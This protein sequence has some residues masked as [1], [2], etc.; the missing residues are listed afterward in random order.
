[1]HSDE[2]PRDS[3]HQQPPEVEVHPRKVKRCLFE[4]E[5]KRRAGK[6]KTEKFA[7]GTYMV[8]GSKGLK[9]YCDTAQ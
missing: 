9:S 6:K 3:G 8:T 4:K 5:I 7:G 1:M 2:H